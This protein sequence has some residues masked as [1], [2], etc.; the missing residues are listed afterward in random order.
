MYVF[1]FSV[2]HG[3]DPNFPTKY[4][5]G[6]VKKSRRSKTIPLPAAEH[7]GCAAVDAA[8]QPASLGPSPPSQPQNP[9]RRAKVEVHTQTQTNIFPKS[10]LSSSL[11]PL[12]E[13]PN[14]ALDEPSPSKNS[15]LDPVTGVFRVQINGKAECIEWSSGQRT[16]LPYLEVKN[17]D[18]KVGNDLIDDQRYVQDLARLPESQPSSLLVVFLDRHLQKAKLIEAARDAL[19]KNKTMIVRGFFDVDAFE[20]TMEGLVEE[21][22]TLPS[23][24]MDVHAQPPPNAWDLAATN[25]LDKIANC[26]PRLASGHP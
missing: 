16:I 13:L 15:S 12:G 11:N 26:G 19:S 6:G 4:E 25:P 21:F 14:I 10:I 18:G 24:P 22:N 23:R 5:S 3:G 8:N 7:A 20:L 1:H 2:K 9:P 17:D